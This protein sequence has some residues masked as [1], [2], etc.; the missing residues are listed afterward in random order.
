MRIPNLI[1]L[2]FVVPEL[3]INVT[4]SSELPVCINKSYPGR[5]NLVA[6]KFQVAYV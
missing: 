3:A 2:S 1:F 4:Q 6:T 5:L